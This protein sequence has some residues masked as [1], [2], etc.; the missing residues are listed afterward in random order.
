MFGCFPKLLQNARDKRL[1]ALEEAVY[2]MTGAS[3]ERFNIKDR[4]TLAKGKAADIT[5]FDWKSIRDNTTIE[6][7]DQR[8]TGIDTV[9][10]NGV[11]VV[12]D[13]I[14]NKSLRAGKIIK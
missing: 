9:F 11:R 5:V 12:E 4:G 13:G 2:K 14:A 7:T 8:P 6:K 10:I 1:I 3:S